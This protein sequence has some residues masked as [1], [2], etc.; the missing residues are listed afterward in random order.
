MEHYYNN[1]S[2]KNTS[3]NRFHLDLKVPEI[4]NVLNRAWMM[5]LLALS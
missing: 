1:K 5:Q 4:L 3:N 2:H